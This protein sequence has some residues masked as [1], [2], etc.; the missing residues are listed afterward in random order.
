M[1]WI[2][3]HHLIYFKEIARHGSISKASETLM[4]GQ[5]AL[6]SQLKNLENYLGVELFERKNRKLIL[7]DAGK[8]TLEYAQK[9]S[10]LGQELLEVVDDGVLGNNVHLSVGALDSI[11]K[12][13]IC[14]V[15]DFA[16]KKTGCF[17][18][19]L[20]DDIDT[21]LDKLLKHQIDVILSDHDIDKKKDKNI[22]SKK[23]LS[24][25]ISVYA[26]PKY[27]NLKRKFP[28]SLENAPCIVP[29]AHSKV[30]VDI[31]RAFSLHN[32]KPVFIAE[33]QDT[34]LQKILAAKGDGLIFLPQFTTK[35]LVQNNKLVKIGDLDNVYSE[36]YLI[37]AKRLIE[38]PALDLVT[39][40]D[41]EKMRL[42]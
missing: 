26:A 10:D 13:L 15:V 42:G 36:Y 14:D 12:H 25:K 39:K 21:L 11:P 20:E 8:I 7:T 31:E 34:A 30:R 5:P 29:T 41:F 19:I 32:V 37:Y 4:V 2:N 9:I 3:Y 18:S 35:E 28:S 24:R 40:Q 1:K 16:H 17:L 6:S 23:I 27:K 33:T 38:N 22:L